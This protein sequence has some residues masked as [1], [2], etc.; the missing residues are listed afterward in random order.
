MHAEA[1]KETGEPADAGNSA[2][3]L[4]SSLRAICEVVS[5]GTDR[6]VVAKLGELAVSSAN[7]WPTQQE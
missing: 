6:L 5:M 4:D 1:A 3:G 2:T 7:L